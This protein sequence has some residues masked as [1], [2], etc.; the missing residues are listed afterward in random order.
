MSVSEDTDGQATDSCERGNETLTSM[1]LSGF[2]D[3]MKNSKL[4]K[5]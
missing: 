1:K 3:K 2:S 4:L 5:K